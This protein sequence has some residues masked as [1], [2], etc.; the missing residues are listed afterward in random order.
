MKKI[1]LVVF[2]VF[3]FFSLKAQQ[4]ATVSADTTS[5]AKISFESLV[6]DYTTVEF[7]GDGDCIFKFKNEGKVPLVLSSVQASCGCTTPSWTREP[8][9]PN[10]SGEI[11]V[12]YDTKRVGSFS[13]TITV[14]SNAVNSPVILRIS[15]EVKPAPA[16]ATPA[17]N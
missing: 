5:K 16:E 2:S 12:H 17:T 4:T 6:H 7:G 3:C 10:E 15:G 11:K 9:M 1:F 8:I 14:T 13:K